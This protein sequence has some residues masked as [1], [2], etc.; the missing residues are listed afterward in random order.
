MQNILVLF[1]RKLLCDT[2]N[3]SMLHH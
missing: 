3:T 2:Q 1:Y